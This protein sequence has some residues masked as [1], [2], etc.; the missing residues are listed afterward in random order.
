[1]AEPTASQYPT[2]YD[3]DTTLL[4]ELLNQRTF[5]LVT[6]VGITDTVLDLGSGAMDGIDLPIYMTWDDAALKKNDEIVYCE[7]LDT[8]GNPV[9]SRGVLNTTAAA[10]TA[11]AKLYIAYMGKHATQLLKA[12]LAA[13]KYQG[14][15]GPATAIP[16]TPAAG[17]V[18]VDSDNDEVYMAVDNS[19]APEF[20]NYGSLDHGAYLTP[21]DDDHDTGANAYHTDARAV[22]WHKNLEAPTDNHNHVQDGDSHDHS[23]GDGAARIQAGPL[24]GRGSA[25]YEREIYYDTDNDELYIANASLTWVKI[26]GAPQDAIGMW[27][28]LSNHSNAC[29]SG[30]T[31]FT[32]L[33][34]RFPLGCEVGQAPADYGTAQ[35]EGADTHTHDYTDVPTHSHTV[36]SF[37]ATPNTTNDHSHSVP[38]QSASGPN[39]YLLANSRNTT[40][41]GLGSVAGH[42][43]TVDMPS[44]STDNTKRTSDDA[45]GVS[46]GTTGAGDGKPPYL[47]VIFCEKD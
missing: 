28:D 36:S 4:G 45:T 5:S 6:S 17:E 32:D 1:M 35:V 46:T 13:E 7:A 11:G 30:W 25:S 23:K 19:G 12:I 16:G 31:R 24:S 20:R 29:P 34:E 2:A 10:H 38:V 18:F 44:D 15:V 9:V 33:D 21:E 39:G 14:L 27:T 8:A 22:T 43:H 3:D 40:T 26:V 47:T 41:L 37:A 42:T